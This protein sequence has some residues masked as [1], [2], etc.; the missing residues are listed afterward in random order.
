[1]IRSMAATPN[2]GAP[3]AEPGFA[4]AARFWLLLGWISFGGP[5]GQIALFEREVVTRRRW[6]T[7]EDFR[8]GLALAALLPGPEALK[9]VIFGGWRL[10]GTRGGVLAGLAFILPSVLILLV[11]SFVYVRYGEAPAVEGVLR[12]LAAVVVALI[13][14]ALLRL[15]PRL[16]AKPWLVALAALAF[17]AFA[18]LGVP[19]GSVVLGSL[20]V[21]TLVAL[22]EPRADASS[23]G[24]LHRE[25]GVTVGR[26]IRLIALAAACALVPWALL[27]SIGGAQWSAA[28]IY[29]L[30][31]R[32]ALL[33]F[34]GAYPAL[35]YANAELVDTAELVTREQAAAGLALAETTPG[36]LII[37]LQFSG[38][39]GGWSVPEPFAPQVSAAAAALAASYAI[40]MPSFFLMLIFAP[41]LAAL[42][43]NR[44]AAAAM[45]AVTA[46]TLTAILDIGW[47][48]AAVTL[49]D[50]AGRIDLVTTAIA[51]GA[52][53]L[54]RSP[55]IPP[56][57][58][59]AGGALT[60]LGAAMLKGIV[61]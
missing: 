29:V 23:F 61:P 14:Q 37:A 39:M 1:M 19:F 45:S 38:F 58:V 10:H 31:L 34:G 13:V 49:V 26:T 7:H 50:A 15:G 6:L 46:V 44:F 27:A 22:R 3:V 11:L 5:A 21:G 59:I 17:F 53:V 48:F 33:A 16:L 30:L 24:R 47:H 20:V 12:G 28:Q 25:A 35:A 52:F 41:F 9:L 2:A 32:V 4:V 42:A 43:R 56:I 51:V 57:G 55:R 18:I 8:Q 60:G 54:L 40:F 36:P